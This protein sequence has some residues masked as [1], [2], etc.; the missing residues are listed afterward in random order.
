MLNRASKKLSERKQW[1]MTAFIVLAVT[2]KKR[3]PRVRWVTAWRFNKTYPVS[4]TAI[5]TAKH[6]TGEK[7]PARGQD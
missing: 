2:P 3:H 5:A 7:I 4:R 6:T 1:E